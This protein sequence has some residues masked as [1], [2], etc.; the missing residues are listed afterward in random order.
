MTKSA[1]DEA[2]AATEGSPLRGKFGSTPGW[3]ESRRWPIRRAKDVPPSKPGDRGFSC[4]ALGDLSDSGFCSLVL[5]GDESHEGLEQGQRL[6]G[7]V[8]QG[9][10][11]QAVHHR[12]FAQKIPSAFAPILAAAVITIG[13]A[14]GV[15]NYTLLYLLGGALALAG[16]A[17]IIFKVKSVR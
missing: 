6:S 7:R 13:A 9:L 10:D 4:T 14:E 5:R 15:K 17:L 16:A 2:V 1:A 3:C 12:Q 11:P 8:E